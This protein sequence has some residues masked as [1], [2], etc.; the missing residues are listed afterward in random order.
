MGVLEEELVALAEVVFAIFAAVVVDKSVLRTLSVAEIVKFAVA[1]LTRKQCSL[2][3]AELELLVAVGEVCKTVGMDIPN[4][5]LRIYKVVTAIDISIM[6]YRKS[7][8][9]GLAE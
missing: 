1:A 2:G 9:A 5:I 8:A 6:L 3:N 4:L 7:A